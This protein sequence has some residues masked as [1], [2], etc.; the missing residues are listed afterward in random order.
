MTFY[1]Y[2]YLVHQNSNHTLIQLGI[3]GITILIIAVLGW[4]WYRHKTDL[5]YRD[6]FIIMV[7]LLLLLVGIQYN[8]WESLQNSFNQ[9]SQVTQIMQRVAKEKGVKK[10][11]VWSNT[12]S[13]SSGMLIKVQDHIYN[14]TVNTDGNSYT[15]TKAT[16]IQSKIN[17]VKEG[18]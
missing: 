8:E 17:Y 7:L 10:T 6:L 14:V 2:N 16:P 11:A 3:I 5:K 9:K 4:L 15:L 1:S 13:V 18:E 12:S